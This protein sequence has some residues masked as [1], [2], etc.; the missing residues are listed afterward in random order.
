MLDNYAVH[1]HPKVS[2]W[3]GRHERLILTSTSCSWLNEVEG[4]LN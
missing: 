4:K 2:E 1:K 3:L